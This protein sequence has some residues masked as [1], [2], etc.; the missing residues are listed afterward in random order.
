MLRL[1]LEE[2]IGVGNGLWDGNQEG[3]LGGSGCCPGWRRRPRATWCWVDGEGAD[4]R[5]VAEDSCPSSLEHSSFRPARSLPGTLPTLLGHTA[6]TCPALVS[7]ARSTTR[8]HVIPVISSHITF[9]A[10][11]VHS[12]DCIFR[13]A[14]GRVSSSPTGPHI[15][16][17][18]FPHCQLTSHIL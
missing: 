13:M 5:D 17:L 4:A 3:Q 14:T 6:P 12:G 18:S 15:H 16:H 10:A 8:H 7:P 9:S 11:P 1:L 2:P